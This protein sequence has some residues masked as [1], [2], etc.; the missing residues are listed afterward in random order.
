[1]AAVTTIQKPVVVV[2]SYPLNQKSNIQA[3]IWMVFAVSI[4]F[5]ILDICFASTDENIAVATLGAVDSIIL[6]RLVVS[7]WI[8]AT[9]PMITHDEPEPLLSQE[10]TAATSDNDGNY[11]A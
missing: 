9:T 8:V 5:L 10:V 7:S 11:K 1:M 4:L 6:I 3:G 2:S